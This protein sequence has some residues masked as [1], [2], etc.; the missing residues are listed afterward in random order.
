[1]V[2]ETLK[3]LV[4]WHV[5][6]LIWRHCNVLF[7]LALYEEWYSLHVVLFL[8]SSQNHPDGYSPA[9]KYR[10]DGRFWKGLPWGTEKIS[11]V[12]LLTFR[13]QR[14]NKIQKVE[15]NLDF[16][17][18]YS[19]LTPWYG[20]PSWFALYGTFVCFYLFW[21]I[22]KCLI[23]MYKCNHIPRCNVTHKSKQAATIYLFFQ[24]EFC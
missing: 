7:S 5:F 8:A 14:G 9:E 6:T 4:I 3:T 18:L 15:G 1:M 24:N 10:K 13:S 22:S 20:E 19:V 17:M 11:R 16:F 12:Q 23:H 2:G 21:K